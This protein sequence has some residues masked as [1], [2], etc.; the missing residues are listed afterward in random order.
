MFTAAICVAAVGGL[1][2]ASAALAGEVQGAPGTPGVAFSGS[3]QRT[4][5]PAHSQSICACNGLNDMNPK[6]GPID[7]IVQTPHTQGL[8]GDPGHGTCAG[9]TNPE[10]PPTL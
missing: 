2:G 10:N 6:Q 7:S 5:A 4:G 9:G 8:P 3:G 1:G